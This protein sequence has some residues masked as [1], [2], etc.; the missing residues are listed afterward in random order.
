M[1]KRLTIEDRIIRELRIEWIR[2]GSVL[3]FQEWI[4]I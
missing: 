2:S 4:R 3:S 1:P